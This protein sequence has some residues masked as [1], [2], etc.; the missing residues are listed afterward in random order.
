MEEGAATTTPTDDIL[1]FVDNID[2]FTVSPDNT[3]NT[4][5][6]SEYKEDL[7]GVSTQT[8]SRSSSQ[9][10]PIYTTPTTSDIW[11]NIAD[12]LDAWSQRILEVEV[13]HRTRCAPFNQRVSGAL[14]RMQADGL[15]NRY[16]IN[17]IQRVAELWSQLLS[18]SSCYTLGGEFAKG[19]IITLLLELYSLHQISRD[20]VVDTC[21]RL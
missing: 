4:A 8:I 12:A 19:D 1:R 18:A 21:L 7:D 11:P 13:Q 5:E 15:L 10:P 6:E 20:L 3:T 2:Y 14:H 17:E 16:D 9:S